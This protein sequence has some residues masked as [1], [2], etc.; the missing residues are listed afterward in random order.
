MTIFLGLLLTFIF[1]WL[2]FQI[3]VGVS[4]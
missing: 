3:A 1:G 2:I 4:F